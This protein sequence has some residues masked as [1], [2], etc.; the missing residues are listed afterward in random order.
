MYHM[1]GWD[2]GWGM[3]WGWF[4]LMHVL[5]WVLL[6]AG[7]VVLFRVVLGPDRPSR[8]HDSALQILRERYARGEIDQAEYAE[9]LKHL[10]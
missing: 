4:G 8:R 10:K 5:W 3:G 6:V 1:Y 7:A 9:R 2:G